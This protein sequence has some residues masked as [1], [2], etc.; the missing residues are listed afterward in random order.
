M[1]GVL[2]EV[3]I[4]LA[5]YAYHRW[6]DEPPPLP[7]PA[8]QPN[9][10]RVDEGA[11]FPLIYGRCRVR[12]PLLAW[13]GNF[14]AI[15]SGDVYSYGLD[16]L[17]LVG[18]PFEG[19]GAKVRFYGMFAGEYRVPAI[20]SPD[21]IT[22]V[23]DMGDNTLIII[24]D[25]TN[26]DGQI[27]HQGGFIEFLSGRAAQMLVNPSD[28]S[29]TS[30][31]GERISRAVN[32]FRIP[33]YRGVAC[34]FLYGPSSSSWVIGETAT[35]PTYSFEM[36]SFPDPATKLSSDFDEDANPADVLYDLL[37][38]KLGKLGYDATLIDRTSFG[39]NASVL[40]EEGHGYSRAIEDT[41]DANVH[42]QSIL[43]QIDGVIFQDRVTGKIKLG[44]ARS[45]YD[46]DD[47]P[48]INPD[49]CDELQNYSTSTWDNLPN[50]IRINFENREKNY[51]TDSAPTQSL[52]GINTNLQVRELAIE[53]PGC[54]T[55]ALAK[56]LAARELAARSRPLTK[57]T[58]IVNRSFWATNV[59]DVVTVTWPLYNLNKVAFRV[60]K[61]N[62]GQLRSGQIAL[63]LIQDIFD[64]P[65]A[66]FSTPFVP[67]PPT[68]ST[69]LVPLTERVFTEAPYW[70]MVKARAAGVI[71]DEN[72]QRIMA[73][74]VQ[75]G[76]ADQFK[77]LSQN[78]SQALAL[79]A[80]V[81]AG[82][83]SSGGFTSSGFGSSSVDVP[84]NLFSQMP[85]ALVETAY[86]RTADPYDTVTNLR[87]KTIAGSL[88]PDPRATNT[89][90]FVQSQ[91]AN[92]G[93]NMI[94]VGREIMAY[95]QATDLGGGVTELSGIWRGIL[96]TVPVDHPIDERIYFMQPFG[97][98]NFV[99]RVG[100]VGWPISTP[101]HFARGKSIPIDGTTGIANGGDPTDIQH[102]SLRGSKPY[103]CADFGLYGTNIEGTIGLAG[104]SAYK[105]VTLLE[106][107]FEPYALTRSRLN[108]TIQRGDDSTTSEDGVVFDLYAQKVG[109]SEVAL[110]AGLTN[111]TSPICVLLGKAGHGPVDAILYSKN[112]T[113]RSWQAPRVRINAPTWRNLLANVRGDRALDGGWTVDTGTVDVDGPTNSLGGNSS[114]FKATANVGDLTVMHQTVDVSGYYP[115]NMDW[116]AEFYYQGGGGIG[117][118]SIQQTIEFLDS[119]A[120]VISTESAG[121][122]GGGNTEWIRS[123]HANG[124]IPDGTVSIR[125]TMTWNGSSG[126]CPIRVTEIGLRIGQFTDELISNPTFDDGATGW[127]NVTHSFVFDT[128]DDYAAVTEPSNTAHGGAFASSE[129]KQEITIADDWDGYQ[130]GVAHLTFARASHLANDTGEVVLEALDGGGAVLAS[131]T[132]GAET[133]APLDKWTRKRLA[134]TLPGAVAVTLRVRL[135]ATRTLGSGESGAFFDDFSLRIHKQLD[136]ILEQELVFDQPVI[137]PMPDTWMAF[138]VAYPTI[139]LPCAVFGGYSPQPSYPVPDRGSGRVFVSFEWSDS[140]DHD[141]G[142]LV[143]N[144][145]NFASQ[146]AAYQFDRAENI[147]IAS[148]VASNFPDG[149]ESFTAVVDFVVN[150][151][152]FSTACGLVGRLDSATL[153]QGWG[154]S[155]DATGHLKATLVGS[156]GTKTVTR[157]GSTVHDGARHRAA[158]AWDQDTQVLRIYDERGH[159]EISTATGLG[160]VMVDD[161][162]FRV[163]RTT[164]TDDVLPGMIA[165]VYLFQGFALTADQLDS[166]NTYATDP[167]DA[168]IT[169]GRDVAAWC[170]GLPNTDA[171]LVK[172]AADH[173]PIAWEDALNDGSGGFGLATARGCTNLIPTFDLTDSAQWTIEGATTGPT[174]IADPTGLELGGRFAVDGSSDG[175]KLVGIPVTADPAISASIWA[176]QV[177]PTVSP[178]NLVIELLDA[179]D[180]VVDSLTVALT[181]AYARVDFS[182]TAWAGSTPTARLRIRQD[183]AGTFDLAHVAWFGQDA[184]T[185]IFP[186]IFPDAGVTMA[187]AVA[188]AAIALPIQMNAEGELEVSGIAREVTPSAGATT[189]TVVQVDNGSDDHNRRALVADAGTPKFVLYDGTGASTPS[190]STGNDWSVPW[191]LR[192]RW[193]RASLLESAPATDFGGLIVTGDTPSSDYGV[194]GAWTNDDTPNTTLRI[195]S[196]GS[197]GAMNA[198]IPYVTVRAR[199]EVLP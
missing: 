19:E 56:K 42:I 145:G 34:I 10:P 171:R 64:N 93:I 45:D 46:V 65:A 43:E 5:D 16:Q 126:T 11:T 125:I 71:T 149:S 187:D 122:I 58:A 53:M 129:I 198:V 118:D 168:G 36:G 166:M 51:A 185:P 109:R 18:I 38:A 195:G 31:A 135:L 141:P 98:L 116:F 193:N 146:V 169:T 194:T 180:V 50:K 120:G 60:A 119:G 158:I 157:F 106:E 32:P 121:L 22:G 159:D 7:K 131:V 63:D 175:V 186:P 173:I 190:G 96:D 35:P 83:P 191:T 102:I 55:M 143:G 124:H 80:V 4:L 79:P 52:A 134:L 115:Q 68:N 3:G 14:Q 127:T 95:E 94:M 69:V 172:L 99:N 81:P 178:P 142:V 128:T 74:A 28:G 25:T 108:A 138:H 1:I 132:T 152:G 100:R 117:D 78:F 72:V 163:G 139:P 86:P 49:N 136:P 62:D 21:H 8:R 44:L 76:A 196:D 27:P 153:G 167:T 66:A 199:E 88:P 77:E 162:A 37:V 70:W 75:E 156:A 12:A 101:T 90:A 6:S 13:A 197:T 177:T 9:L 182:S 84:P 154:I 164:D 47:V 137:Q 30:W 114:F 85:T 107:G 123:T 105:A 91:I 104:D 26:L 176:R 33:G 189:P 133:I 67:T 29:P 15:P 87:I 150:E 40:F 165:R 174:A 23:P 57:C 112:G 130:N 59:G 73:F 20:F 97:G 41:Q 183:G 188:T 184:A 111:P 54:K 147:D 192:G 39:F 151:D 161:I 82:T 24:A 17:F 48:N 2:I 89:L 160:T 179:A 144:W 155:I 181:T 92:N 110:A 170:Q 113:N 103:P 140:L 61:V 148:P